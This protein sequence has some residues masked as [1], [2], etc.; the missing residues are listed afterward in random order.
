MALDCPHK[1]SLLP[2]HCDRDGRVYFDVYQD[3]FQQ[4]EKRP[5]IKQKKKKK[6]K[7]FFVPLNS[8]APSGN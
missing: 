1:L 8:P 7:V 5:K 3:C 4:D 6:R 2:P